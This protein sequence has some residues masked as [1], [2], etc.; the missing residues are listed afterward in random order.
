[1]KKLIKSLL[2]ALLLVVPVTFASAKTTTTTQGTAPGK[3]N[4][5]VFYGDGCSHCLALET[6]IKTSLR[7]NDQ[8]KDK[9]NIIYYE[10]WNYSGD[11]AQNAEL[12]SAVGSSL[13][14]NP[15]GVP[16][17]VIGDKFFSGYGESYNDTIVNTILDQASNNKYVD[18]VQTLA[19]K[20]KEKPQESNPEDKIE[21]EGDK[22]S[23]NTDVI[24]FVILGITVVVVL[25][26]CFTKDKDED[27]TK[28]EI[29]EK[30]EPK[31]TAKKTTKSKTTATKKSSTKKTTKI[32]ANKK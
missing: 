17:Y 7:K 27:T 10:V 19:D 9:V 3:V 23:S 13:G 11:H 20:M 22:G 24:G 14:T 8:V 12:M 4:M 15:T 32:S 25:I 30:A 28:E 2:V 26:I 1:M 18:V 16:F 6:Y 21:G 31:T 29:K 5:Y